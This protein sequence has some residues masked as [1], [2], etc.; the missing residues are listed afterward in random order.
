MAIIVEHVV[1]FDTLAYANKL[2]QAGVPIEQAEVHAEALLEV[3]EDRIAT[4]QDLKTEVETLRVSLKTE[5]ETLRINTQSE[6]DALRN[7][8]HV[9]MAELKV[10][11]IKWMFGLLMAQSAFIVTILKFLY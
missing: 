2:K 1:Y 3:F 8:M 9:K 10:D 11:L 6:I 4:K 5:I 7:D